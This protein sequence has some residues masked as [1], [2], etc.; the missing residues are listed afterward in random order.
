MTKIP[1]VYFSTLE[2]ENIRCFGGS[3]ELVLT[4]HGRPTQ[5]SLIIGENGAGKTTLLECLAW[6]RP[7]PGQVPSGIG[8]P[9]VTEH[10]RRPVSLSSGL[11][12]SA[13][14]QEEDDVLETLPRVGSRT[15]GFKTQFFFGESG[16]CS[17]NA[18]SRARNFSLGV[19]L[20]FN[21]KELLDKYNPKKAQIK[22]LQDAFVLPLIVS[23]GANRYLGERNSQVFDESDPKDYERLSKGTEL[24]D[25]EE[26]LMNLDYAAQN[27]AEP[28]SSRL[29][30]L[31]KVLSR[32]L[33][34][35]NDP[36]RI[37]IHPP[38]VLETGRPSGVYVKTFTGLVR[39]SALS[40]GY[41][42]TAG[43]VMDLAWRFLT[44]YP[45]S[46]DPLGE[47]AVVLVDE[48]DLHLHPR[49]QLEIMKDLS[50]LFP[51]TQFIATS[52][53]PLIVQVAETANLILLIKREGDVEIVNEPGVSREY[54]VD[55]IL[56]SLLFGVP[57]SRPESIERLFRQRAK[58]VDKTHRSQEEEDLLKNINR[59]IHALPTAQDGSAW[60]ATDFIHRFSTLLEDERDTKL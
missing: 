40:L 36:E 6:M 52:H 34:G 14:S 10:S 32:I 29:T 7:E 11:L 35:D 44:R 1:A 26:I 8:A 39:M 2:V 45:D 59:R 3:Q 19:K 13:L 38:D 50:S 60:D 43:W 16:F 31:K 15:V 22:R 51:A 48:I 37:D 28:E 9:G 56:T 23:Y 42:T 58:L 25:V 5:W 21:E 33:P 30:L 12:E 55:Q 24:C 20:S 18:L 47:P 57:S 54:R 17:E 41:R 49:W 53:S 27:G 46:P 4:D